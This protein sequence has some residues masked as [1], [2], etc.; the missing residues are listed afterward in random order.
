MKLRHKRAAVKVVPVP[1][2]GFVAFECD[3]KTLAIAETACGVLDFLDVILNSARE[4]Y[5][6]VEIV[7][8]HFVV[9]GLFP[10][11]ALHRYN[12]CRDYNTTSLR[13]ES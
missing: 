10:Y 3:L 5:A 13:R 6:H 4:A 11:Y 7:I 1:A 2:A 9:P 8:E 12:N